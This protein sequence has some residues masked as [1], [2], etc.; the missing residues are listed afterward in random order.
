[1][2]KLKD[3]L[4]N[5][6]NIYWL[7]LGNS[8]YLDDIERFIKLGN[9]K[10]TVISLTKCK[11]QFKSS[12]IRNYE[13]H[14]SIIHIVFRI[15]FLHY[16]NKKSFFISTNINLNCLILLL[17][18]RISPIKIL[19]IIHNQISFRSSYGLV[20]SF[21]EKSLTYLFWKLS[22]TRGVCS[23]R[24]YE[25]QLKSDKRLKSKKTLYVGF[26]HKE[27]NS[28]NVNPKKKL[29]TFVWGRQTPYKSK[30]HIKLFA[31]FC[32]KNSIDMNIFI[33]S[34]INN[35]KDKLKTYFKKHVNL[36]FLDCYAD[37]KTINYF[38]SISTFEFFPYTDISQSGP[39]RKAMENNSKIIIPIIAK[40]QCEEAGYKNFL[41][42]KIDNK[43][44]KIEG[45]DKYI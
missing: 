45:F 33:L 43:G 37:N 6:N 15:L 23:L 36:I 39:I 44:L 29:T 24:V 31:D 3:H 1:M 5:Y 21:Y 10:N 12:E 20:K 32:E 41:L 28:D 2:Y 42:Y 8:C 30:R 9:D 18:E 17:V 26:P 4:K 14:R 34:K 35:N 7:Y 19:H 22:K 11:K 27:K 13:L 25:E 38:R 40:S 16:K